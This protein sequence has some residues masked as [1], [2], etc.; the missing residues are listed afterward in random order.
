MKVEVHERHC[1][2]ILPIMKGRL[3]LE[4]LLHM[5]SSIWLKIATLLKIVT[6]VAS[7]LIS[8]KR[9]LHIGKKPEVHRSMDWGVPILVYDA[10]LS[11]QE[12][13]GTR[14]AV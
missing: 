9:Y 5:I 6:A 1:L 13:R 11:Q 3:P 2:L 7:R 12:H 10:A 8:R 14:E 4:L